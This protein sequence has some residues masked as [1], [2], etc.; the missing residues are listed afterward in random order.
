MCVRICTQWIG[1]CNLRRCDARMSQLQQQST[2]TTCDT[3]NNYFLN[4]SACALCSSLIPGCLTCASNTTCTTCDTA[5]HFQT[6]GSVCACVSGYAL[7]GLT[8][9]TCATVMAG[10]L[11]C[12][13]NTTCTTC[14]TANLFQVSGSTCACLSGYGLNGS[15]CATCV[16]LMSGCLLCTSNSVCTSQFTLNIS[17]CQEICG[18]GLL[19][20]LPCDDGNNINGDGCSSTCQIE[21]GYT[22]L[23]VP[24]P[25]K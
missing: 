3:A 16:S 22:L 20:V 15:T 24:L 19:F 2:C 9:A 1:M 11:A 14:D 7:N 23:Y 21:S 12:S 18:D 13:S 25:L 8:C 4:G 10:C 5:N 6:S 17:T